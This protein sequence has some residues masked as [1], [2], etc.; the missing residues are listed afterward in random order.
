MYN[1]ELRKLLLLHKPPLISIESL[2]EA[3]Q[4]YITQLWI[5]AETTPYAEPATI[6]GLGSMQYGLTGR[7][8]EMM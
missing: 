7:R 8:Q 2:K 5:Y 6:V 1:K 3:T 4:Y